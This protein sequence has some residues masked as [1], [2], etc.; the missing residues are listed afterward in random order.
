[1]QEKMKSVLSNCIENI[2][3]V[4][5]SENVVAKP[6]FIND[7]TYIIPMSKITVGFASGGG[8]YGEM[9]K[10]D[11]LPFAGGNGGGLSI[12]PIG[13][14][15]GSQGKHNFIKLTEKESE[16]KWADLIT[17]VINVLK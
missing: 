6:I 13:V 12:T 2:K 17:S 5:E 15:V 8:E 14:L 16:N 4:I 1:M 11:N 9:Q 7:T 3:N 10:D